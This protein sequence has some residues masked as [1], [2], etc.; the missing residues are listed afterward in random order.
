M[1]KMSFGRV[2]Y[3]W[4]LFAFVLLVL[5]GL[6]LKSS[7]MHSA[8]LASL[9]TILLVYPTYPAL[10]DNKYDSE[11]CKLIVRMIAVVETI[12]SF[13]IHTTF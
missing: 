6:T 3:V 8:I 9:G 2:L 11:K 10:L 12:F 13:L 7:I 4:F 1:K 5:N